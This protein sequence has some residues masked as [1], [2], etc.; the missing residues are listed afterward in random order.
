MCIVLQPEQQFFV[1]HTFTG[2]MNNPNFRSSE[3][4]WM[5]FFSLSDQW[6]T[7][8]NCLF[9]SF[10]INLFTPELLT[11]ICCLFSIG[12]KYNFLQLKKFLIGI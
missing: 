11:Y 6:I 8:S 5:N 9:K 10:L 4:K 7:Y 2:M 1:N 3:M 12:N